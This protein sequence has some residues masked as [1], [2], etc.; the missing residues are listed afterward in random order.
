M[1]VTAERFQQLTRE[2]AE[3]ARSE[4]EA[5]PPTIPAPTGYVWTLTPVR[6]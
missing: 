3:T 6:P 4:Y 5:S 1:Q 2:R